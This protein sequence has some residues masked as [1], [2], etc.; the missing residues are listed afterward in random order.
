MYVAMGPGRMPPLRTGFRELKTI[1][2]R[3]S[4]PCVVVTQHTVTHGDVWSVFVQVAS[5]I[6]SLPYKMVVLLLEEEIPFI[7]SIFYR[8]LFFVI[9]HK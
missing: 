7:R 9:Y 4:K 1:W 6:D 3:V 5:I 8:I 2:G